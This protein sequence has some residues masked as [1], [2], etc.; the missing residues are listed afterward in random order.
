M[1]VANFMSKDS[2]HFLCEEYCYFDGQEGRTKNFKTLTPSVYHNLLKK[3][4]PRVT[5]ER[6]QE[7]SCSRK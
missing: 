2:G 4:I 5:M 6:L 1:H 3:Q 7:N